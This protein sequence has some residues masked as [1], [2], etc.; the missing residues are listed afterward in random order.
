MRILVEML[1][2]VGVEGRRTPYQAVDDGALAEQLL[3][4]VGA[5]LPGGPVMSAVVCDISDCWT[6]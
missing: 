2:T 5:V 1:N 3:R 4:E 6:S